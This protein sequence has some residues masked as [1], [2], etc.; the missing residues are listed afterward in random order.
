VKRQHKLDKRRD[1]PFGC[2]PFSAAMVSM[3][4]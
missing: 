1:Q 2:V 3:E 4:H